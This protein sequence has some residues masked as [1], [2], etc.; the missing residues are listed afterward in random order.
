M[1][2][3][4]I[5]DLS[6]DIS[7]EVHLKKSIA[8]YIIELIILDIKDTVAENGYKIIKPKKKKAIKRTR[9]LGK[10]EIPIIDIYKEG[11]AATVS[12]G[13]TLG[14]RDARKAIKVIE[15]NIKEAIKEDNEVEVEELGLFKIESHKGFIP[16]L[17]FEPFQP[18]ELEFPE[19][20][21]IEE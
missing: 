12:A 3:L 17:T 2:L 21:V 11:I 5:K 10:V 14:K 1:K 16:E 18:E 4:S 15:N 13:T 6:K 19:V 9:G 7:K 8:R 20:E